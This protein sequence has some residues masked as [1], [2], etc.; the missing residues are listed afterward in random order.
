MCQFYPYGGTPI[1]YE[2]VRSAMNDEPYPMSLTGE[3][4]AAVRDVVNVGIDSRLEACFVPSR[5][6]SFEHGARKLTD[7]RVIST[8]LECVV[9]VESLPILLRRLFE[10]GRDAAESLG[11]SILSTLDLEV[12]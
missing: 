3:D 1:T 2:Q 12:V 4:A 7:G 9:S 5:G 11:V 10:I 8:T 6:D